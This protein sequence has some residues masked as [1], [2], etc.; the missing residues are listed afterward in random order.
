MTIEEE[1]ENLIM[2]NDLLLKNFFPKYNIHHPVRSYSV[3]R[4]K[5]VELF[6][7]NTAY[8]VIQ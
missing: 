2:F 6:D 3:C 5:V 4:T 8:S 7:K 1:N